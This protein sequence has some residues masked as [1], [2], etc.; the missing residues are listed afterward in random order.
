M[1]RDINGEVEFD[2]E[3][4]ADLVLS[5]EA[6]TL[7]DVFYTALKLLMWVIFAVCASNALRYYIEI[8]QNQWSLEDIAVEEEHGI[9]PFVTT[10]PLFLISGVLHSVYRHTEDLKMLLLEFEIAQQIYCRQ[11]EIVQLP[12]N[13]AVVFA[14]PMFIEIFGLWHCLYV[15]SSAILLALCLLFALVS[16]KTLWDLIIEQRLRRRMG[17]PPPAVVGRIF[18]ENLKAPFL[19]TFHFMANSEILIKRASLILLRNALRFQAHSLRKKLCAEDV[20]MKELAA[21][22]EAVRALPRAIQRP[23]IE[24]L[25]PFSVRKLSVVSGE[26]PEYA[27]TII[28][29]LVITEAIFDDVPGHEMYPSLLVLMHCL[30]RMESAGTIESLW[31]ELTAVLSVGPQFFVDAVSAIEKICD[32]Q[33]IIEMLHDVQLETTSLFEVKNHKNYRLQNRKEQATIMQIVDMVKEMKT[34]SARFHLNGYS[35]FAKDNEWVELLM[36]AYDSQLPTQSAIAPWDAFGSG[37][38]AS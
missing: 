10:F 28:T 2:G 1:H 33:P 35:Q 34:L 14:A 15:I 8:V 3:K 16:A 6:L 27:M 26:R 32:S 19:W 25:S 5:D 17:T 23:I 4:T 38:C 9:I 24:Y 7:S 13:V 31:T 37:R 12:L 30:C 36:A 22:K 21:Y 29:K 11:Q 20:R 18:V